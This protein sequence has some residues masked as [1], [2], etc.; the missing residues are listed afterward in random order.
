MTSSVLILS[1]IIFIGI[2]LIA[3]LVYSFSLLSKLKA[4]DKSVSNAIDDLTIDD[5][6][7]AIIQPD[8]VHEK[9]ERLSMLVEKVKKYCNVEHYCIGRG[10][11]QFKEFLAV[12][13][14]YEEAVDKQN[15]RAGI[16][17]VIQEK[18]QDAT[19][20][21]EML[22]GHHYY[23][24][25]EQDAF[26][27]TY[28]DLYDAVGKVDDYNLR[29]HVDM[30]K[31]SAFIECCSDDYRK[32]HNDNYIEDELKEQSD[33]FDKVLKYPLD[34]QQRRAI[35]VNEDNSL[36]VSA[37]GSGKTSTIIAKA[38]YLFD[39]LEVNPKNILLISYTRKAAAELSER[40][41]MPGLE[42]CTF[43]KLA[44]NIIGRQT[45]S[46]PS[47][48][49]ETIFEEVFYALLDK[50]EFKNAILD[51]YSFL[52][53]PDD[54][55]F[56][57]AAEYYK[58]RR[59]SSIIALL[60]DMDG[61]RI[62]TR[63]NEEKKICFIL[64][65]LGVKFRYEEPYE[66]NTA[67]PDHRQYRP[68]FSIYFKDNEGRQRRVYLEHFGIDK[69]GIV[70]KWFASPD[71][72]LSWDDANRIYQD[73]I[74][75]KKAVH[76]YNGTTLIYTT[77]ADFQDG[78]IRE[79]LK[80]QLLS[81]GVPVHEV[82]LDELYSNVIR[83]DDN[84]NI[85]R[86]VLNMIQ[87]FITLMKSGDRHLDE[88][89]SMTREISD[90]RNFTILSTIIKPFY[91]E[92]SNTLNAKGEIDFTDLIL[93]ATEICNSNHAFRRYDYILVD[94]FQDISLDRYRLLQSLRKDSPR[95]KLF[96]VG[97]DW[98]SIFRFSGSDMALFT[99]FEDYF[100]CT[101]Q[102]KIET[103]YRFGEPLVSISSNF[104]LANPNQK[105]KVIRPASNDMKTVI[106]F[107]EY[108]DERDEI[109]RILE[110]IPET[111]TVYILGR[112]SFDVDTIARGSSDD[113]RVV[114]GSDQSKYIIYKN[115][116][117]KF[118]TI[119][120]A[121]GLEADYVIL[122]NC[123][124]GEMGYG[125]PSIIED[126]PILGFV[127]SKSDNFTFSEERRLFYVAITRARKMT[128]VL[129]DSKHPSDFVSE[130]HKVGGRD[131][132]ICPRCKNGHLV[133][134][135]NGIAK[136][137]NPYHIY[138]CSNWESGCD[139]HTIEFEN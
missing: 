13:S 55:G 32:K 135:K 102:S 44:L 16:L 53:T 95:T 68:D 82:P 29:N 91:G 92:Y 87:S 85:E 124:N 60:P 104:I 117:M 109:S 31:C 61:K 21:M 98:Q 25:S 37:A 66:C 108:V 125:F 26:R 103:T 22:R 115:R 42:C 90:R 94:E 48:C 76:S 62:Y 58:N 81:V 45:G 70:P 80:K 127:L 15:K 101:V 73:E 3:Y 18:L 139:Y 20:E 67:D 123:N 9:L 83:N 43:H 93:E 4:L 89:I 97:D 120:Q 10:K 49:D 5:D 69:N 39:K 128:F 137:G 46:R 14:G 19:D 57:S 17:K 99:R 47:I 113:L 133:C 1:I 79:K 28:K 131:A 65:S 114:S 134:Y 121:K 30:K 23:S 6:D 129:Y 138:R 118:L 38:R 7:L 77:S 136:N 107:K 100:G 84:A 71:E 52:S 126:D 40:L 119:H 112:Y 50:P 106:A 59:K 63:S 88:L 41:A 33:Y 34:G 122:L 51:Y 116:K 2:V 86:L 56:E 111:S 36:V 11:S 78:T 132:I 64:S 130:L 54:F 8:A 12:Y 24:F 72:G 27:N 74:R 110:T 75:W 35:V 105:K 96:C